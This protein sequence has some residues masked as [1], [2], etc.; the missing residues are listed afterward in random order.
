MSATASI[1]Y[2]TSEARRAARERERERERERG[3]SPGERGKMR[4]RT[5][6]DREEEKGR[7]RART[8]PLG[9]EAVGELVNAQGNYAR[10]A[11]ITPRKIVM[12]A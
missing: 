1:A 9:V 5:G 6:R 3:R 7:G 11:E 8:E 12:P 10:L 2:G 4:R